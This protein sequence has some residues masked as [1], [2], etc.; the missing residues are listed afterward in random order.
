MRFIRFNV[1]KSKTEPQN[2]TKNKITMPIKQSDNI[3]KGVISRII[4]KRKIRQIFNRK[5]SILKFLQIIS[6]CQDRVQKRKLERQKIC[7]RTTLTI[8]NN[9]S[10]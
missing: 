5:Q 3:S 9:V 7:F 1:S 8:G 10:A 2:P 6:F 4:R